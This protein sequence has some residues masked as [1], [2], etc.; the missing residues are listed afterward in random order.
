[1]T[2]M[3][4]FGVTHTRNEIM[5]MVAFLEKLPT[6]DPKH[7]QQFVDQAKSKFGDEDHHHGDESPHD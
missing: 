6:L 2:G 1:M 7:Y 3:P 5:A 4:S